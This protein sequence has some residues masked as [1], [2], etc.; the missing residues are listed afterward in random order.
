MV[1]A[2]LPLAREW[3]RANC[4]STSVH[5]D[6]P[7]ATGHA[8]HEGSGG[9][10]ATMSPLPRACGHS[11]E[12]GANELIGVRTSKSS[13]AVPVL[14]AVNQ[15]LIVPVASVVLGPAG[16]AVPLQPPALSRNLPLR[17]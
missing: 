13:V 7:A 11:D 6:A 15:S 9:R 17:L 4:V 10:G 2:V 12:A 8:C 3:C 1:V 14:A 5:A 16:T